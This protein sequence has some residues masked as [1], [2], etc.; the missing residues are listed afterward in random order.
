MAYEFEALFINMVQIQSY[1]GIELLIHSQTM[2]WYNMLNV[3][4]KHAI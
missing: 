4:L 2:P 3:F 1:R